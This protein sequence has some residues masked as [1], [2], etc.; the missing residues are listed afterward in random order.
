MTRLVLLVLCLYV[1]PL[2]AQALSFKSD[3]RVLTY[4]SQ[5]QGDTILLLGG[6]PGFSSWN[7]TPIQT[8]LAQSH[9][10]IRLDMRG[11]AD[12]KQG[13]EQ[14]SEL[15]NLWLQD[16]EAL[17]RH[18]QIERWTLIGHSWGALMAQLYA[19]EHPNHVDRLLLLNPVDPQLNGLKHLIER[20]E[21]RQNQAGLV[22]EPSWDLAENSDPSA[23][24]RNQLQSVL[25]VYFF[26]IEQGQAYARQFSERDLEID[27][28]HAVWQSYRQRPISAQTL[29]NLAK[30]IPINLITCRQDLLMPEALEG[31]Q[32][33]LPKLDAQVLAQ[34]VHFP[35]EEQADAFYAALNQALQIEDDGLTPE[36]RAWLE[37]DTSMAD[38]ISQAQRLSSAEV[39]F[40]DTFDAQSQ[41]HMTNEIVLNAESL[42]SGW[43]TLT[44]CHYNLDPV[45]QLQIVYRPGSSRDIRLLNHQNI[46]TIWTEDSSVQM[47]NLQKGAQLCVE[48][49]TLALRQNH[50]AWWLERGPFM[51][52]FLDGYYPLQ[53]S[54]RIEWPNELL[55]LQQFEPEAQR[56]VTIQK[57]PGLVQAEY[58][59]EGE[60]RPLFIFT[61]PGD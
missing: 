27:I 6:G 34:C 55:T 11:I 14:P 37:D 33:I 12:N 54:L 45:G 23:L 48:M 17:R 30:N 56:G 9:R 8:H 15:L 3:A 1:L 29:Q 32:A 52:K 40:I 43:A 22:P 50:Q 24:T 53:V 13:D 35:W 26:D 25:P 7:L 38:M 44:Q 28:N 59:F 47:Q 4:H 19:R 18:L 49:Q 2:N 31:Y 42:N 16:L 21:A 39:R 61:R 20:I 46:E 41:Y 5:G 58:R 10:V 57:A 51:R 60:L 36:E